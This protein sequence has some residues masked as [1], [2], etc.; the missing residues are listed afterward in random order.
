MDK[1][2]YFIFF[3]IIIII[4]YLY[5]NRTP[6]RSFSLHPNNII[7]SPCDGTVMYAEIRSG[8]SLKPISSRGT[9]LR[10]F[11]EAGSAWCLTT[12]YYVDGVRMVFVSKCLHIFGGSVMD[13][14]IMS[15]GQLQ[16]ILN[17]EG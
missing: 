11:T 10:R 12:A 6:D 9:L 7:L 2:N 1:L 5:F 16:I 17:K 15:A 3:I 13:V 14:R 4:F 8:Y